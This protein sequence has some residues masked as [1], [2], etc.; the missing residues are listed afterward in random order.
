MLNG[1]F[2]DEEVKKNSNFFVNFDPCGVL[3]ARLTFVPYSTMPYGTVR[4]GTV[5]HVANP[6]P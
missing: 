1:K 5:R 4:Y 3:E 6:I 2:I